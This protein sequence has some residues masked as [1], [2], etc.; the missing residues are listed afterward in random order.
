MDRT[1]AKKE[2][3][4]DLQE[5][6]MLLGVLA[7]SVT[8]QIGLEPPDGP[9]QDNSNGHSAGKSIIHN[10]NRSRYNAFFYS[11]CTSF[12]ASIDVVVLL[13]PRT[14]HNRE[15]LLWPVYTVIVL[16]MF[17]LLGA[18][19]AGSTRDWET[20][21]TVIYLFIPVLVYVAAYAAWS[22]YQRKIKA[23]KEIL[24]EPTGDEQS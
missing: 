10:F 18:Y 11:N 24:H 9:W 12:M 17:D 20:S 1:I 19:A 2:K 23:G 13:L 15:L 14:L 22:F 4:K 6:L 8:Y 16:N 7:A 21:R 3:E 5:Y